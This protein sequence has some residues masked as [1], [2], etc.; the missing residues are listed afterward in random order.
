MSAGKWVDESLTG[1]GPWKAPTK[2]WLTKLS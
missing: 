1:L 2:C